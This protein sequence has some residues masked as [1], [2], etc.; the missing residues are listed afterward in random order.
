MKKILMLVYNDINYD[1]R[2]QRAAKALTSIGEVCVI[3]CGKAVEDNLDFQTEQFNL[4]ENSRLK[5]YCMFI[6]MVIKHTKYNN[7]DIVYAH[8]YFCAIPFLILKIKNRYLKYIYD[9]HEL[10][11]PTKTQPLSIRKR[12]FYFFEKMAIKKADLVI[13]AQEKRGD[14]MKKHYKLEKSPLVIQ[15]ISRLPE[16]K[17]V[18]STLFLKN[19][20]DFFSI[21]GRTVVYAGVVTANRNIDKLVDAVNDLGNGYK[22]LIVGDGDALS[23]IKHKIDNLNNPNIIAVGKLPYSVL[24]SI[25]KYCDIGYL[26]YSTEGLNNLYCAPNKIY[27]YSSV[28]LP[29]VANENPTVKEIMDKYAIGICDNEI[30]KAI[31]VVSDNY[32]MYKKNIQHFDK[33]VS[34]E[35]EKD[36][37]C[38]AI[39]SIL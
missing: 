39:K 23:D 9:A 5:K 4:N 11:I 18:D 36:K 29:I 27:E 28:H 17:N 22:L 25:L 37:L 8:D 2:V 24:S 6:Q 31:Q 13:C 10:N 3:S 26:Y 12:F 14:I 33:L 35:K 19:Y 34:W 21:E 16:S 1:A 30:A 32:Q 7:Y 15:N 20:K 38:N